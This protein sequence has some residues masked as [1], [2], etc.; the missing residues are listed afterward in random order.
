MHGQ[1]GAESQ[2]RAATIDEAPCVSLLQ[3]I[4]T[5]PLQ[6][7][8]PACDTRFAGSRMEIPDHEYALERVARYV[9]CP[10]C[11]T[12]FQEPMPGGTELAAFYPADY[13]SVLHGGLLQQFRDDLRVRRLARLAEKQG[14]I[15]D[16]GCGDGSF[17]QRAALALPGR[18]LWGF[19]IAELSRTRKLPGGATIVTGDLR[20]LLRQLPP[21]SLI[22]MN[23]VIEHLPDPRATVLALA[24]RLLPGGVF[25]GQ[26]PAADSLEHAVFGDKWS[27]FHSPRH[28]V[29]FSKSGLLRLL[30]KCGLASAKVSAAFNPAGIAVSLG[31]IGQNR[32]G[33][34]Q[35][36]GWR[37]LL[38]LAGAGLLAP[39]DLFSGRPGIVDFIAVKSSG[40]A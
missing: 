25:E 21:C 28:T 32:A 7:L 15:L 13:H 2:L 4:M 27:G 39:I 18:E 8:C 35:R 1:T 10:S 31:T 37:W 6:S 24:E 9:E 34:I 38:L 26:T 3:I 20:D 33:R 16:F 40:A 22:T 29:V 11:A 30:G 14:A 36:K 12:L 5:V 17:L 23:H 19:E